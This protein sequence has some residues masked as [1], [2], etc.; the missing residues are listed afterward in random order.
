MKGFTLENVTAS[1]DEQLVLKDFS[2]RFDMD[3]VY[4]L[5]GPSG[6]G[7]T[8]LLR[9]LLGLKKADS[10]KLIGVGKM[11]CGTVFQEDRLC[12]TLSAVQNIALVTKN[13]E[14]ARIDLKYLGLDPIEHNKPVC[15][16]SGGQRRRAALVRAVLFDSDFLVLDEPFKGL[17]ETSREI[18]I[19]YTL[20]NRCGRGIILVTHDAEEAQLFDGTLITMKPVQ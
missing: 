8:T 12:E 17:D 20:E 19:R 11:R 1:Y 10:G 5:M 2:A 14:R 18:A 6:C 15:E 9:L 16:L 4:V 13:E 3:S 7:K